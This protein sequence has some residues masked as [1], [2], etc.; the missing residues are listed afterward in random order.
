MRQKKGPTQLPRIQLPSYSP[1]RDG[2]D[3]AGTETVQAR[4][5][6]RRFR[7]RSLGRSYLD[8]ICTATKG[9][10]LFLITDP[11]E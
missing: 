9:Q 5:G 11:D 6:R 4:L 7:L 3:P 8:T 1:W 2:S 10:I